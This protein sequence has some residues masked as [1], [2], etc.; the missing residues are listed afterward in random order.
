MVLLRLPIYLH[1]AHTAKIDCACHYR[2]TA[3]HWA[4][5]FLNSADQFEGINEEAGCIPH[6]ETV[7][8]GHGEGNFQITI[9]IF[10]PLH[11]EKA[12]KM[13]MA[14]KL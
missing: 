11:V 12:S 10:T 2:K 7:N 9:T 8:E 13:A 1:S 4:V 3:R 6:L 14:T 5:L